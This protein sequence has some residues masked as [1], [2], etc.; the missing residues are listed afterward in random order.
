MRTFLKS[1]YGHYMAATGGLE[2]LH[3]GKAVILTFHRVRPGGEDPRYRAMRVLDVAVPDF[4]RMLLWLRERYEPM[5]LLEW[6]RREE[7]PE[8]PAFIVTFDDGWADNYEYAFPVLYE[9]GIPATIFLATG[10]VE[11]R[12]PFW[13]QVAGLSDAEIEQQKLQQVP[14]MASVQA[15]YLEL[16]KGHNKDFLTWDQVIQM[17]ES[18]LITFG[19]HGHEHA[20]MDK[21]PRKEA[22]EDVKRCWELLIQHVPKSLVPVLAWP[23]GNARFDLG[24]EFEG[25]GLCAAV[26][27]GRGAVSTLSKMRWNLPRNNVDRNTSIHPGLLPW[28]LTRAT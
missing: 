10:A 26:G 2:R 27:T 21:L 3:G 17:G 8:R 1:A 23:N 9:L 19:P 13:W 15:G 11:D 25:L 6:V 22:L 20:L 14:Y 5:T 16:R 24:L 12:T 18:G 4:R 28:L 7:P